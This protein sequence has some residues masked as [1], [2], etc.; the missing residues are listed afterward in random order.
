MIKMGIG[1]T[2]AGLVVLGAVYVFGVNTGMNYNPNEQ[3]KS[4]YSIKEQ[5][6]GNRYE[7]FVTEEESQVT[8]RINQETFQ[9]ENLV[10]GP[11]ELKK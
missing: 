1:K 6:I 4:H 5:R 9:L 10:E 7:V 2:I 8:K 3:I 11:R